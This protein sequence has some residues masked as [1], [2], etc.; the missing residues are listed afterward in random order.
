MHI[1]SVYFIFQYK[2]GRK[3]PKTLSAL[4]QLTHGGPCSLVNCSSHVQ[5]QSALDTNVGADGNVRS[6]SQ[7]RLSL[8]VLSFCVASRV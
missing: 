1:F 4:T 3:Q 8:H 7:C 5:Q 2:Y 6:T